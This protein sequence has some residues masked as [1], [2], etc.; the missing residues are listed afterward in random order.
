MRPRRQNYDPVGSGGFDLGVGFDLGMRTSA[1][2][3]MLFQRGGPRLNQNLTSVQA[4]HDLDR[5]L[6]DFDSSELHV[7]PTRA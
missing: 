1:S 7:N 2:P 3:F 5:N 6:Q 4:E